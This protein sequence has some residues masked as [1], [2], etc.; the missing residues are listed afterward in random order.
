MKAHRP[1]SKAVAHLEAPG[2]SLT[3]IYQLIDMLRQLARLVGRPVLNLTS[4]PPSL[5]LTLRVN[6]TTRMGRVRQG[7]SINYTACGKHLRSFASYNKILNQLLVGNME[8][9]SLDQEERHL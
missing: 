2:I 9:H 4:K 6:R 7:V 1:F 3:V 5:A 8:C